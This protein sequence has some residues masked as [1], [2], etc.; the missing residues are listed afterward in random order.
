MTAP[1]RISFCDCSM[2]GL[3]DTVRIAKADDMR[4]Q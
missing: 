2:P 4:G 3:A 1:Y